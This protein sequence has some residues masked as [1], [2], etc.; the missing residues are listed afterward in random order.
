MISLSDIAALG[1]GVNE[2][3]VL[4]NR[5]ITTAEGNAGLKLLMNT[6]ESEYCGLMGKWRGVGVLAMIHDRQQIFPSF[7]QT[8]HMYLQP[9]YIHNIVL[10]PTIFRRNTAG[11]DRCTNP[12]YRLGDYHYYSLSLCRG[13]CFLTIVVKNCKCVSSLTSGSEKFFSA[14]FG[15]PL[16]KYPI[17][18]TVNQFICLKQ[19]ELDIV[20]N[21]GEYCPVCKQ[22]CFETTYET[23]ITSVKLRPSSCHFDNMTSQKVLEQEKIDKNFM[24]NMFTFQSM[25]V[26][27]VEEYQSF[28]ISDLLIYIGGA[29]GLFIGMSFM[30][31]ADILQYLVFAFKKHC[32]KRKNKINVKRRNAVTAANSSYFI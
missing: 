3:N 29:I 22:A 14:Q 18:A 2:S 6:N 5:N 7:F 20:N 15:I 16:D 32:R 10:A 27:I 21:P 13:L 1:Y 19:A 28:T 12:I 25:N 8:S 17:C 31:F 23:L 26:M 24:L 11:L 30:S 9:G 4:P